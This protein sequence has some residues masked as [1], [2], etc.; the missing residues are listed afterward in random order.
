MIRT[1][2]IPTDTDIHLS[3]PENYV[4]KEI[5]V[6]YYPL[7]ELTQTKIPAKKMA[8]FKQILTV[9]EADNLQDYVKKSR[10]EW[11]RDF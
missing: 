4:G 6:M 2:I 11:N 10:E 7:D 8:D 5:E 3:I 9:E 1:T